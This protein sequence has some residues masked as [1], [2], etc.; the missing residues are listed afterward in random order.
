MR[1]GSGRGVAGYIAKYATKDTGTTEGSDRPHPGSVARID[2]LPISL[3][4]QAA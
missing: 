1:C 2:L 3:A 4:P